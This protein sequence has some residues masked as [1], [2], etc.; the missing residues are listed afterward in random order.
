VETFFD[1]YGLD[2]GDEATTLVTVNPLQTHN[3]LDSELSDDH[4]NIYPTEKSDIT[5]VTHNP[6]LSNHH[7]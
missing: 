1:I 4:S 2:Y 6:M 5:A 3:G 7:S